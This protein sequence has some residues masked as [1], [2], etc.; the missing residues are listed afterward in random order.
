MRLKIYLNSK[1]EVFSLISPGGG[2][3]NIV[4]SS[5]RDLI[6]DKK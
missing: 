4:D 1:L 6:L 2:I 3:G 5:I